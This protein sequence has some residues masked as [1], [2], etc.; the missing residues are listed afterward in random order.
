MRG[1]LLIACVVAAL[2]LP[3]TSASAAT[4]FTQ[5]ELS[6]T[7]SGTKVTA[8]ATIRASVTTTVT[9]YGICVRDAAGRNRD[10]PGK[11]QAAVISVQATT[12][13]ATQTLAAGR[14]TYYPCV[15]R[16]GSWSDVG[17]K[18][19]TVVSSG[20][21]AAPASGWRRVYREDFTTDAALGQ[22][23]QTYGPELNGYHD[24]TPTTWRNGGCW[25]PS[26][27]LSVHD[28]Y[29]DTYLHAESGLA[30]GC[31][32]LSSAPVPYGWHRQVYGQFTV[33]MRADALAGYKT[34]FLLW[35]ESNVWGEGEINFPEANL[36]DP[37]TG[38]V[39]HLSPQDP[40]G[41][42]RVEAVATQTAWHDYTIQWLPGHVRMLVDGVLLRDFTADIPSTP[43]YWVLQTETDFETPGRAAAGHVLVDSVTVD[44]YVG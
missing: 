20:T 1:I 39:H 10:F 2:A 42:T 36:L 11:K 29:L 7:V 13:T 21:T 6:A 27:T 15:Q 16:A 28:G 44:D 37:A 30:N 38:A 31:T 17:R 23:A 3:P 26:K 22:V 8:T 19:F 12:Y 5:V 18:S 41:F 9:Q 24:G 35:P 33:R 40:N 32:Y 34:A 14:Y 25:Y 43:H 4:T